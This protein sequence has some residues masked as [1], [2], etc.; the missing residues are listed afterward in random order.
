MGL[1]S[2]LPKD[3]TNALTA[4]VKAA[5]TLVEAKTNEI[6]QGGHGVL[7]TKSD[8]QKTEENIIMKVSELAARVNGIEQKTEK[9]FSEVGKLRVAFDKLK[10]D[11]EDVEVPAA[12]TASV[13]KIE[14]RLQ[15]IDELNED[16]AV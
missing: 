4:L 1:F 11:L 6:L 3:L 10:A 15:N 14:A 2:S 9:V 5:K 13:E 12:V 8:L 7:V 16:E